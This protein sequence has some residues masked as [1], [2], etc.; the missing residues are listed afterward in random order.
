VIR[1][2]IKVAEAGDLQTTERILFGTN[3]SAP[4]PDHPATIAERVRGLNAQASRDLIR[5]AQ[6]PA[7]SVAGIAAAA[8]IRRIAADQRR[9]WLAQ[10]KARRE[11]PR[12]NRFDN[13]EA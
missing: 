13:E 9:L 6:A 8:R 5:Q 4:P 3:P 11:R 1:H 10:W 2:L 7:A 12:L